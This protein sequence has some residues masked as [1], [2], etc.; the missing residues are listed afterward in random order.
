MCGIKPK[1]LALSGLQLLYSQFR[2][3]FK[4]ENGKNIDWESPSL[5]A[6]GLGFG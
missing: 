4:I 5:S 1:L 6:A 2:S 3:A